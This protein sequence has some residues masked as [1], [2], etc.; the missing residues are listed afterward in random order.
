MS[1]RP[2]TLSGHSSDAFPTVVGLALV[3][4]C[5]VAAYFIITSAASYLLDMTAAV[6]GRFWS[7]RHFMFVHIAAGALALIAGAVQFCLAFA[8]RTSTAHRWIGRVYHGAVLVSCVASL[9]ILRNGSV[10]GPMWVAL[11][12]TLAVCTLVFTTCGLVEARR[13]RWLHHSAWMLRS[14]AGMM[15]F[16]WFRLVWELPVLHTL[17]QGTRAATVLAVTM[18]L[19]FAATELLLLMRTRRLQSPLVRV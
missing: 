12:V 4:S 2:S 15:V 11:L 10:A 6:Y 16:A 5:G 8:Q 17:P 9:L 7:S 18:L 14:Y 19:T 13:R 1:A 3:A